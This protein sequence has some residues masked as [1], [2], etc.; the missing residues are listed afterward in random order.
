[1]PS[2][3]VGVG[4]VRCVL[5]LLS[6]VLVGCYLAS[7]SLIVDV[8]DLER[9]YGD[10]DVDSDVPPSDAADADADGDG[11][12]DAD[13]DGGADGDVAGDAGADGDAEEDADSDSGIETDV[14]DAA[15]DAAADGDAGADGDDDSDVGADAEADADSDDAD[16]SPPIGRAPVPGD[17]R[18][19][20]FLADPPA[21]VAGDANCDGV[22]DGSAQEDEFVEIVNVGLD[23][24]SLSGVTISD[25]VGVRHVFAS[26]TSLAPGKVI[27]VFGGGAPSCA[28]ASDV[29]AA[30]ASSGAFSLNNTGDTIIVA[31]GSGATGTVLQQYVYGS[32]GGSDTSLTLSPDL[33][34]TDATLAGVGGFVAHTTADSID[35]SASSPGT[36]IDG[37]PF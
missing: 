20:E 12:A 3:T 11:D 30:T 16:S 31:V 8:G 22:R 10:G 24:L 5:R 15:D 33:A 2:N 37:S 26:A 29:Q 7:C 27:V 14:P 35:G 19:N 9:D 1:M 4:E 32:E 17:L 34:D 6:L 21:G 28:W 36:R 23:L 25:A 18:L 13:A